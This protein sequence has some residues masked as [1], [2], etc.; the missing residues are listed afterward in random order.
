MPPWLRRPLPHPLARGEPVTVDD[1]G[2]AP[3]RTP[4]QV[5]HALAGL[6]DTEYDEQGRIIGHGLTLRPTPHRLT[7]NGR[8][9]YTWCA[10]NTLIFPAVLGRPARVQSP[11]HSTGTPIHLT[12]EPDTV[13]TLDPATTVVSIVTQQACSSIRTA[14]CDQVKFFTAPAAA[15]PW[16]DRH[17]G[18]TVL[19]VGDAVALGRPLTR[20]LLTPD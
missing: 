3:C 10:L 7:V 4:D 8:Q 14:F 2:Q 18:A 5:R 16:L 1:L 12:V 19:P 9:L 15:Q 11:C 6:P 13:T 20:M 17:P